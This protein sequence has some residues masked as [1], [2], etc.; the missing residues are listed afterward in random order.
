MFAEKLNTGFGSGDVVRG[1][2]RIRVPVLLLSG[3]DD[4]VTTPESVRSIFD[5]LRCQKRLLAVDRASHLMAYDIAPASVEREVRA[6][7]EHCVVRL[8]SIGKM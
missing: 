1:A 4:E 6:F 5:N 8:V 7:V 3:A 2:S